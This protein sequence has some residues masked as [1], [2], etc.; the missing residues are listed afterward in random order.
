MIHKSSSRVSTWFLYQDLNEK[1]EKH[2]CDA[3]DD[4]DRPKQQ[5]IVN[6]TTSTHPLQYINGPSVSHIPDG[7]KNIKIIE[8]INKNHPRQ[9]R[10]RQNSRIT[11]KNIIVRTHTRTPVSP[12]A[13][14]FAMPNI[15]RFRVLSAV[16]VSGLPK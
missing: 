2:P 16:S 6:I 11:E 13:A 15:I 12:S 7:N 5:S 8:N 1:M 4:D 9:R 3:D 14:F 10:N